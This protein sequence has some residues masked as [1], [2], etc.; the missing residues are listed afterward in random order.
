MSHLELSSVGALSYKVE[1]SVS[2]I[3]EPKVNKNVYIKHLVIDFV[4]FSVD[5]IHEIQVLTGGALESFIIQ[6]I[7]QGLRGLSMRGLCG[8][9]L[10][11][12]I[13]LL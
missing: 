10:K 12:M 9:R 8:V 3:I 11:V 1:S 4:E 7:Q 2:H 13:L 5:N 6:I